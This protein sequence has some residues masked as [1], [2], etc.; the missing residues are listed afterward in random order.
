MAEAMREATALADQT[1]SQC[2]SLINEKRALE[3]AL[4]RVHIITYYL[5]YYA[6]TLI[7]VH[8]YCTV[9]YCIEFYCT[10]I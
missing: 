6:T 8:V 1:R 5:Q 9:L 2:E 7:L 4:N 10:R 3:S